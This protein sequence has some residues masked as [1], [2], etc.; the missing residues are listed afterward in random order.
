VAGLVKV[1]QRLCSFLLHVTRADAEGRIQRTKTN[2]AGEYKN[3][4]ENNECETQCAGHGAREV[5]YS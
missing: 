2:E 3:A 4:T 1:V 5:Q